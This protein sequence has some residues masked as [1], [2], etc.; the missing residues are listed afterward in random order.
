MSDLDKLPLHQL[1]VAEIFA[2]L[3]TRESGLS[4]EEAQQRLSRYGADQ[5]N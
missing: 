4:P 5:T 1:T 2:R 3:E